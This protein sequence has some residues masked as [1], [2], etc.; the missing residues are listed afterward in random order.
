V[1]TTL[2]AC[3]GVVGGDGKAEPDREG[4]T[5]DDSVGVSPNTMSPGAG[6]T[7]GGTHD[8]TPTGGDRD[9]SDATN[10]ANTSGT[11]N[12]GTS[13]DTDVVP[14]PTPSDLALVPAR[15]RRLSNT[16]Y[17]N[18][19]RALLSTTERYEDGL[20]ADV[21]QRNFTVNQ[22]QTVS[23][24]WNAEV[25]RLAKAAAAAWVA[26]DGLN[27]MS[28]CP[29]ETT[30]GC[31]EQFIDVLASSAFRR[32][33]TTEEHAD[34]TAIYQQGAAEG[35]FSRG[36]EL[37]VTA[38]LQAPSFMYITEL[39]THGEAKTTLTGEE[40][41]TLLAYVTTQSPP[42]QTLMDA[43]RQGALANPEQRANHAQRLL[44]SAE[45]KKTLETMAL[46]WFTADW[47]LKAAK[48]NIPEFNER[49]TQLFE[50][51][52]NFIRE[53]IDTRN[54][55]AHTLL[56]GD[57]TIVSQDVADYYA[58]PGSG[59]VSLA[60]T[61]RVGLITQA[62]F[63]GAHSS[64]T[65]S[66]PVKRGAAFL[67]Q[68]LCTDPPDPST[69][70]LTVAAPP[71]D[72]SKS[73][74]QLFAAHSA[75]PSCQACHAIID[76]IGFA[77]EQFDEGGRVRR[78]PDDNNGHEIE[79][80]GS[81]T[82]AGTTFAFDDAADLIRQVADSELGQACVARTATRFAFA[83]GNTATELA[84]VETWKQMEPNKRMQL[85]EVLTKL[86]ASD[87]F[88]QRKTL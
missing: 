39:G 85:T 38:I 8:V 16:E 69:V 73:T 49:R 71:P 80:S 31:A 3:A 75:D 7:S 19:V 83:W 52:R 84:F 44:S 88:V 17:A 43:G 74:R 20:P 79:V 1:G 40:I 9:T 86:I 76:P 57:F 29:G 10:P 37:V 53:V 5:D 47:V 45:G 66:S 30:D 81:V 51:S 14:L 50:E 12:S 36:M 78:G 27:R 46:E 13:S 87:L 22:A 28:P 62:A 4:E 59:Q 42:D 58:F 54:A 32:E 72:P 63:L 64:P 56:T 35:Q 25:E 24:D 70:N 61:P 23:S 68:V 67:R 15:I 18:S 6:G 2:V 60:G 26:S 21:R 65:Q 11:S 33:V 77:F 41:A 48:D 55:D 82:V 34:L